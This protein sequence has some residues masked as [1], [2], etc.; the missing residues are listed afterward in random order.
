VSY[1]LKIKRTQE[2]KT[3]ITHATNQIPCQ[4]KKGGPKRYMLKINISAQ[5][6]VNTDQSNLAKKKERKK[7]RK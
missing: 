2:I 1:H 7:E 6:M 3:K 5:E 4:A